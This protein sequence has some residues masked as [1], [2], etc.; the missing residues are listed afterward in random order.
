MMMIGIQ[1]VTNKARLD[2]LT[3]RSFW[4]AQSLPT[5][6]TVCKKVFPGLKQP[7]KNNKGEHVNERQPTDYRLWDSLF[8]Q[9]RVTDSTRDVTTYALGLGRPLT[10]S[11]RAEVDR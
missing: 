5:L 10:F 8:D 9:P 1:S 3:E 2:E 11:D 6:R 4:N 7:K